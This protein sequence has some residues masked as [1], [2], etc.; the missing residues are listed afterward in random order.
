MSPRA[1]ATAATEPIAAP[2]DV[3]PLPSASGS[4]RSSASSWSSPIRPWRGR[5][6]FG[7]PPPKATT[8]RRLPRRLATWPTAIATPSATSALR[9]SAVPNVIEAEASSTIQAVSA[10]S[11]TCTRT[12]GSR[13]RAVTFQSMCRT[14]SPGW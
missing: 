3:A 14:S 5:M 6:T 9:R 8:P 2:S 10:R 12:C 11:P 4:L 13:I 1:R 7:A